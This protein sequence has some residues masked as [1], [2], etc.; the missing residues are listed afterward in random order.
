[1]INYCD[2]TPVSST[3]RQNIVEEVRKT[4][5]RE[6]AEQSWQ[7]KG[8]DFHEGVLAMSERREPRFND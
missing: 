4:I 6:S 1:M 5:A 7:L 8:E 3:L 2:L